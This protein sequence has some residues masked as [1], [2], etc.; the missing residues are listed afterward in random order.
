MKIKKIISSVLLTF[1]FLISGCTKTETK[2]Q[3]EATL[4]SSVEEEIMRYATQEALELQKT[5][6]SIHEETATAEAISVS[7]TQTSIP[8]NCTVE[9]TYLD[10]ENDSNEK[11]LDIL[12]IDSSLTNEKLT[13]VLYLQDLP[14]KIQVGLDDEGNY[15]HDYSYSIDI[16]ADNDIS[17]SRRGSPEGID[18]TL[19]FPPLILNDVNSYS[20]TDSVM[21]SNF[22]YK[23][24]DSGGFYKQDRLTVDVDYETNTLTFS[25]NIPGIN[26]DSKIYIDTGKQFPHYEVFDTLCK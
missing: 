6:E 19:F 3:S 16:D 24:G 2:L 21:I 20:L 26:K 8:R 18:H 25:G 4:D 5:K 13:V 23:L 17:T 15:V 7:Q 12:K 10:F 14:E 22:V 11:F 1:L 9:G